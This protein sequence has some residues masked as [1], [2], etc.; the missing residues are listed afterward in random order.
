MKRK[1]LTLI[2]LLLI[3]FLAAGCT[4]NDDNLKFKEEYEALNNEKYNEETKFRE[5]SIPNNNPF[6]YATADDIVEMME[7][8]ETFYAYFGDTRC[9]WC[10]SVIEKAIEVANIKGIK[11]IYYVRIWDDDH[12][13]ILRDKYELDSKNKPNKVSDGTKAYYELLEKFGSLLQDYTLTTSKGNKVEVGEKRIFAPEFVYVAKG[14]A[15]KIE[16]GISSKLKNPF[17]KLTKEMLNEE[18]DKFEAFFKN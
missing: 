11:K 14:K 8:G 9:P 17:D 12:N 1:G 3:T 7:S 15:Q 2:V 6:V 16:T 18:N 4:K 13:E 10:R 5:I